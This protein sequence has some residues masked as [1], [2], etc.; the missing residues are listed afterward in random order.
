MLKQIIRTAAKDL[1]LYE[2]SLNPSLQ[3]LFK[4]IGKERRP[5]AHVLGFEILYY[6]Q[7]QSI[8]KCILY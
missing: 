2:D 6:I 5:P 8:F 1:R 7:S 4:I 3:I